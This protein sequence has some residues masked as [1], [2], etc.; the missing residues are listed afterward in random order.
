MG[1]LLPHFL[2]GREI[3][4]VISLTRMEIERFCDDLRLKERSAGTVSQYR[5]SLLQL[6]QFLPKEKRVN[7]ESLL[8]WKQNMT[9][10]KS[11]RT[12]NCMLAAVNAF[13]DF[14]GASHLKLKTLKCQRRTFSEDELTQEEFHA[15]IEQAQKLGDDQT[16][17]LLYAMSGSGV[18]VSEV[19]F[20][21]VE[22][23]RQRMAVISLKG[24]TRRIPLGEKVCAELL[25]LA[26]MQK[27]ASGPIFLGKHGKPLDR[28]RIWE[29]MKKLCPGAGVD[30]KK[31]H[32]HA[33]RHLFARLFYNIT[34]DIAKLA[35]L[36]GHSS[37]ETTRIYI[38]TS[39]R[40]HRTI[41]DRLSENLSA[42]K[43]PHRSGRL[44]LRT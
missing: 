43:P 41:L 39:S 24:K 44:R 29:S 3:N 10:G 35:D 7:K 40:E 5:R 16:A 32:P 26:Q 31:V 27:I 2:K 20:L 13:L 12:V 14:C 17:T 22:A 8:A 6:W 38:M 36:L 28:R 34:Q 15:L 9:V 42:K 23:A 25:R 19:Q 37:I 4:M 11:V 33:L 30:P 21:T 18:R 1:K